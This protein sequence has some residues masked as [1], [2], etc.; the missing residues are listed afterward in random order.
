MTEATLNFTYEGNTIKIQCKRNEYMK[1]IIKRYLTKISKEIHDILFMCNGSKINEEL[2]LEEFNNKDNEIQI[3]VYNINDKKIENKKILEQSKDIICPECGEICLIDIKDYKIILSKCKNKHK[4]ENILFDEYNNLQ[5]INELNIICDICRTN[6]NEIYNNQ[7]YKCCKCKIIICPLC[8]T[9]HNN[10]H[11]LIDYELRNY[12][13]NI[14]G[15]RY[16]SFCK[17][18]NINLCDL[19]EIEHNKN[20]KNHKC[21]NLNKLINNEN[22]NINELRIKIDNLKF[23]INDIITKLNIIKENMEIYFNIYNTII[24]NYDLKNKNYEILM[25]INNIYNYNK[26]VIKDIN[27]II[28][29]NKFENKFKYIYKIYNKMTIA[30][31]FILKYKIGKEKKNKNIWR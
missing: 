10:E 17:D 16:I 5:K 8:K 21:Y 22:N 13:C 24:K 26:I 27:T 28:N 1:D 19:C 7:L 23:E 20:N 2:K 25:N 9:K 31:E 6:R 30:N 18:C 29:E 12:L 14:H 11:K 3:L 4:R 15:E